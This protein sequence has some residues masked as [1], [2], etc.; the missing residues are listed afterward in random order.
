MILQALALPLPDH[1]TGHAGQQPSFTGISG[2]CRSRTRLANAIRVLSMDAVQQADLGHPGM[3]MGMADIAVALLEIP[4]QKRN[5]SNP[6]WA[7]RDRFV[8]SRSWLDAALQP[9]APHRLR[10]QRR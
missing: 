5:P 4:S 1:R 9:P 3:P 6:Q 10:R 2:V 7:D 8:L